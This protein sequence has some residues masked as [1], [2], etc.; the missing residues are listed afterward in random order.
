MLT[1]TPRTSLRAETLRPGHEITRAP[2]H[3]MYGP[4]LPALV[5]G[6]RHAS[7]GRVIVTITGGR[8]V[9]FGSSERIETAN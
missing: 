1:M 9:T 8:E 7:G 2:G 4:T 3:M 5:E 6:V